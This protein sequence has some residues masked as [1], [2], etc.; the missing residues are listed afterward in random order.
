MAVY[1]FMVRQPTATVEC[2][3]GSD[4]GVKYPGNRGRTFRSNPNVPQVF[5]PP[6]N[7]FVGTSKARG[8]AAAAANVQTASDPRTWRL[9]P[10]LMYVVDYQNEL[11]RLRREAAT[12]RQ[13]DRLT[14]HR[15]FDTLLE[16]LNSSLN[17]AFYCTL[18]TTGISA[19]VVVLAFFRFRF[20]IAIT[21]TVLFISVHLVLVS[22]FVTLRHAVHLAEPI[23]QT[24]DLRAE[25]EAEQTTEQIPAVELSRLTDT[26]L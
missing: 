7:A 5:A 11:S 25:Q 3:D 12:A 17:S 9:R 4:T 19:A 6:K 16:S 10:E 2:F 24:V 22:V 20:G 18:R 21:V 26:Y 8:H 1:N 14:L 13:Q 15:Q 23:M